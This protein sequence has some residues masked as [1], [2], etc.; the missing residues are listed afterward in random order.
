MKTRELPAKAAAAVPP[1]ALRRFTDAA[2][3]GH[4][5]RDLGV[6]VYADRDAWLAARQEWADEHGKTVTQW[7]DD[8]MNEMRQ[9]MH[10]GHCALAEANSVFRFYVEEDDWR[11]PRLPAA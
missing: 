2:R 11:D 4:D 6:N 8:L 1:P 10:D 9:D 3:P 7:F 5:G